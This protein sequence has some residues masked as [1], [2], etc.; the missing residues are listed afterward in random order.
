M[1]DVIGSLGRPAVTL[2]ALMSFGIRTKIDLVG[3]DGFSRIEKVK[4]SLGFIQQELRY[5]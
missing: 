1:R 2:K 4:C 5:F 3:F